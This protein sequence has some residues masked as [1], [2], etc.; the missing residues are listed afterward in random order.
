MPSIITA[1]R[2]GDG[3]VVFFDGRGQ[4]SEDIAAARIAETDEEAEALDRQAQQSI[5][6]RTVIALYA[7]P[8]DV[9]DGRPH[10]KSIREEIRAA[11]APTI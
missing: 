4:W 6:D 9:K 10:P 8:V 1:N 3:V 11:H 7:M 5:C 2:L